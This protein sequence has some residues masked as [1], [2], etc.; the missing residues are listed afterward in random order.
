MSARRSPNL[1]ARE[2]HQLA[3][4][5]ESASVASRVR[6]TALIGAAV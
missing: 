3:P 5:R 6:K 1:T 4:I 2:R